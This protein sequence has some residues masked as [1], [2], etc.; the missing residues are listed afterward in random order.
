MNGTVFSICDSWWMNDISKLKSYTSKTYINHIQM[1]RRPTRSKPCTLIY[2]VT[3]AFCLWRHSRHTGFI[4]CRAQPQRKKVL[5]SSASSMFESG[6]DRANAMLKSF[7]LT[8][9]YLL[10]FIFILHCP[11]SIDISHLYWNKWN[12]SCDF[13][14]N[15]LMLIEWRNTTRY[16]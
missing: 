6:G 10:L 3:I 12:I 11:I 16:V 1:L 2:N 4:L 8:W 15:D 9:Q 7:T 13:F 14:N 5:H